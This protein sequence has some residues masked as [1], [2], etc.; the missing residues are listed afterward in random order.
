MGLLSGDRSRQCW[1]Q[2]SSGT[3]CRCDGASRSSVSTAGFSDELPAQR[4]APRPSTPTVSQ[5]AAAAVA[6]GNHSAK[7]CECGKES[8]RPLRLAA[9]RAAAPAW[10]GRATPRS[11]HWHALATPPPSPNSQ[12]STLSAT[13]ISEAPSGRGFLNSLKNGVLSELKRKST[14]TA[15]TPHF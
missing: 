2:T 13:P 3:G 4:T 7:T 6:T 14:H 15:S 9:T 5:S 8:E 10:G 11:M 1:Y 12:H